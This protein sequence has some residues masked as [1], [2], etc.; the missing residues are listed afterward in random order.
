MVSKALS[1]ATQPLAGEKWIGKVD[2]VAGSETLDD[3]TRIGADVAEV[4]NSRGEAYPKV[5]V[6]GYGEIPFPKGPFTPNNSQILRKKFTPGL[7][8]NFKK[9][10]IQQGRAWPDVPEGSTL[11][12]HHIKPL[13]RG[14][15]NSF[16]NL[17]PLIHP[18]QHQPFTNWWR[19]Y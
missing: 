1:K 19:R 6:E 7:K 5:I 15:T 10:W 4:L 9:W 17:V 18:E 12:I 16:D 3:F 11:N 2:D 13:S 14:G 8:D